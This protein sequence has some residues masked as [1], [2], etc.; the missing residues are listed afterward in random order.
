[1]AVC[2]SVGATRLASRAEIG[3]KIK[4]ISGSGWWLLK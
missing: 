1:M 4:R 3:P 2:P